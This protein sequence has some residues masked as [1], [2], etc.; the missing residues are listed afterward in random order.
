MTEYRCR[1]CGKTLER[2]SKRWWI[3]SYCGKTGRKT[4]IWRVFL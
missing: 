4:R 3:K 1:R 2:D